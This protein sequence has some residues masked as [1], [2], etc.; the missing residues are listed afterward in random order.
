MF[1]P[2][3]FIFSLYFFS[4]PFIGGEEY[5]V[6]PTAGEDLQA[7]GGYRVLTFRCTDRQINVQTNRQTY[8]LTNRQTDCLRV[9][10]A[11]LFIQN[12]LKFTAK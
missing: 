6:C 3:S 1:P 11:K 10:P 4:S 9:L 7:G 5:S 8:V 2:F 12:K